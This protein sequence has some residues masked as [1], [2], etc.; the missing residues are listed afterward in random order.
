MTAPFLTPALTP[1]P[2][3]IRRTPKLGSRRPIRQTTFDDPISKT[4]IV[5]AL[6][7][8]PVPNII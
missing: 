1:N 6:R 5:S 8:T 2:D 7:F 4:A 3:P